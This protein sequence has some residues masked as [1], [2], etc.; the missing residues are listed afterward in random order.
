MELRD[1]QIKGI[2]DI[3][4]AFQAGYSKVLYVLPTGGGKTILTAFM[5]QNAA[6][7]LGRKSWFLVHRKQLVEQTHDK[8]QQ[9]DIAHGFIKT[10]Q[11][12]ASEVFVQIGT[13]QTLSAIVKKFKIAK[14]VRDLACWPETAPEEYPEVRPDNLIVDECHH[15]TSPTYRIIDQYFSK[16][17]VI[18]L[19]ATP[20]RSDGKGLRT[21]GYQ[22]IVKGPSMRWLIDNNYLSDYDLWA[23]PPQYD[24]TG[25]RKNNRTGDYQ[26]KELAR[27][28]DKPQI[29]GDAI[30]QYKLQLNGERVIIF[31]V[32][33][34]HSKHVCEEFNKA[35]IPAAHMDY[36]TPDAERRKINKAFEDGEIL[37]ICNNM[38]ISEGYD[39]PAC[40]GI[41]C[42]RPTMS[43]SLWLQMCGRAL[44]YEDNKRA[45][46]LDQTGNWEKHGLPDDDRDWSL[47]GT[48]KNKTSE[49]RKKNVYAKQCLK[50]Y[51]V[52]HDYRR[53]C[54]ACGFIFPIQVRTIDQVDG[55]L[56]QITRDKIA[57]VKR[58]KQ[59]AQIARA[60][61]AMEAKARRKI[62]NRKKHNCTTLA[63]FTELAKE[64]GYKPGWGYKQYELAIKMG[65][66]KSEVNS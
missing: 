38:L 21:A 62:V 7:A 14:M 22:I 45:K 20:Q 43:L 35:G 13:V 10:A 50:C 57:E 65:R 51:Y 44:R 61:E 33:N 28:M 34:E 41:I 60:T 66:I 47:D 1:Y 52:M 48:V 16:A 46:I 40:Y 12:L 26:E 54:P 64:M 49:E 39:C 32:D 42:L 53:S 56:E 27:R 8:F 55:D 3:R 15:A 19:T 31:C 58:R 6:R 18:G 36:K 17:K 30:E 2:N 23:P 29:T 25:V 5:V 37:A 11:R 9:N 63:E 4:A 59:E 24:L